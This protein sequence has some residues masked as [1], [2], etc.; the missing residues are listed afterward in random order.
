MIWWIGRPLSVLLFSP[1]L[2]SLMDLEKGQRSGVQL[3]CLSPFN[4]LW[5]NISNN[6]NSITQVAFQHLVALT[7]FRVKGGVLQKHFAMAKSRTLRVASWRAAKEA[8]APKSLPPDTNKPRDVYGDNG[9]E[10]FNLLYQE[11][12]R[13]RW[14][15][16]MTSSRSPMRAVRSLLS[17]NATEQLWTR[18]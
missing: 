5:F 11:N 16:P 8:Q 2:C 6:L 12:N 18:T 15:G 17:K 14:M 3:D 4:T 7:F 10:A 9:I 13:A 1:Q